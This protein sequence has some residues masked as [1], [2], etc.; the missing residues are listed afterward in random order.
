MSLALLGLRGSF[1]LVLI[2]SPALSK[3]V[4]FGRELLLVNLLVLHVEATNLISNKQIML[5]MF[6]VNQPRVTYELL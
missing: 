1:L 4:S 2:G 5:R 3:S 6:L